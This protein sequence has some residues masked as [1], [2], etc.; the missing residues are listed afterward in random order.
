MRG[1]VSSSDVRVSK[2][3][4]T[5][6]EYDKRNGNLTGKSNHYVVSKKYL[7]DYYTMYIF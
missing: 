2:E 3:K 6:K 5:Y 4:K 1:R 7:G